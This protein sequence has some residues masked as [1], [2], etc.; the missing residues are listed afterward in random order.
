[1]EGLKR[2]LRYVKGTP[3]IA[4]YFEK[5]ED[6]PLIGYADSDWVGYRDRISSSGFLVEVYGAPICWVTTKQTI[7]ALSSTMAVYVA[8]SN[9]AAEVQWLKGLLL[10]LKVKINDSV[11]IF[12]NNQSY[13]HL[14]KRREHHRL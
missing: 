7:V 5:T 2:I 14:F 3:V 10:D 11:V 4:F 13:I 9:A 1:M 12:E 6:S 8:L